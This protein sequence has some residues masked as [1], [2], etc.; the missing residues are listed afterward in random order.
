MFSIAFAYM[1]FE[2]E[3]KVTWAIERCH[4][5][6]KSK[7]ISPKVMVTYWNNALMN[8]VNIVFPK[9]TTLLCEFH[10]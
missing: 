6:L 7:D 1:M 4:D 5:L 8:D 10:I 2:K 3:D 9:A